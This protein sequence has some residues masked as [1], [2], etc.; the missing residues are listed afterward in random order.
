VRWTHMEGA[1]GGLAAS[2]RFPSDDDVLA[3]AR[4]LPR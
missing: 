4:A 1:D 3:A 2:G